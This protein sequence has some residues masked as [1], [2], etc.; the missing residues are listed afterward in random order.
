MN[1]EKHQC[2][3][4]A[5]PKPAMSPYTHTRTT[6]SCWLLYERLKWETE[7]QFP[8]N[9]LVIFVL[10]LQKPIAHLHVWAGSLVDGEQ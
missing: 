4:L 2:P 6:T 3:K 1:F 9:P 10:V 7:L 5:V 8:S